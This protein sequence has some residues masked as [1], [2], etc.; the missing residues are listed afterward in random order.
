[1]SKSE[2]GARDTRAG[3]ELAAAATAAARWLLGLAAAE[4][5]VPL[6]QTYALTR[7]VVREAAERWPAWW[8]A[9]LFG[10]PHREADM[11]VLEALHEGLRRLRLVRRRGRKLQATVQGRKLAADPVALL[12]ALAAD[13]GGGD[14]FSEM[15]ADVVM[16][17]LATSA[18]CTHDQLAA[19]ALQAALRGGWCDPAGNEP[20]ER[21]VSWVVGGV[22][23]RGEA[24]GLINRSRDTDEPKS[25]RSLISLS[26]AASVL[27]G[28]DRS[29]SR[30]GTALVFDAELVGVRGVGARI[31]VGS[32]GHLTTL[33][34]AIQEAFGWADDHLYSFWLDGRFWGDKETE[35]SH[36]GAPDSDSRTADVPLEELDLKVGAQIAYVFDY[37]DEW[38][39]M[40]TLRERVEDEGTARLRVVE[41]RGTAPPQ[42]PPLD[43]G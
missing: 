7:A 29:G 27:V 6:T 19:S 2:V 4:G 43:D 31:T 13:L 22:L 25:W 24:Y 38:R 26:D 15:V 18:P 21:D 1:M 8:D 41:R 34:D 30:G 32:S 5:G 33:H 3:E 28:S 9:D 23:R 37:G 39:V 40:L 11:A 35:Y 17:R 36:P 10:P 14:P 12:G 16:D 20:E 42:Y